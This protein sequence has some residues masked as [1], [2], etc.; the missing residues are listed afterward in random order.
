MT[1]PM[2][3]CPKHNVHD[4]FEK[5]KVYLEQ[6]GVSL[7]AST[8][9]I[10]LWFL[11]R[12]TTELVVPV[13][14]ES[15]PHA[16][17]DRNGWCLLFKR[18]IDSTLLQH[19]IPR[20]VYTLMKMGVISKKSCWK[21]EQTKV[22]DEKKTKRCYVVVACR[23]Q[24]KCIIRIAYVHPRNK[25]SR[26]LAR[27]LVV[28]LTMRMLLFITFHHSQSRNLIMCYL[29]VTWCC[30]HREAFKLPRSMSLRCCYWNPRP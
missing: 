4:I 21:F 17:I 3:W 16:K 22:C 29:H 12:L 11:Q 30:D 26:L 23:V 20:Y 15:A 27:V 1:L 2:V 13:A 10:L 6:T 8:L 5:L 28:I 19:N 9:A 25:I 14:V 18:T 24:M 7:L